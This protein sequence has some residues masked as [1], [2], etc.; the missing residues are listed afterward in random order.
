MV[1]LKFLLERNELNS[2]HGRVI[3]GITLVEDLAVVAMTIL[4]P[5]L[6][7][8][9]GSRLPLFLRGLAEA[10]LILGPLL[11]VAHRLMP[12]VL[13]RVARMGNIELFLLVTVAIAIGTAALTAYLGLSLALGAFLAGLVISES[14]FAHEAMARILPIRDVFVAMFFVS[15]GMLVKPASLVAEFPT[16]LILIVIVT[17]GKFV[18]WS[19]IV[20]FAGYESGTAILAGLGLTQIRVLIHLGWCRTRSQPYQCT[21]L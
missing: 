8:A 19:G 21:G 13:S 2:P 7:S 17:I 15:I 14:E 20:R 16:V 9:S 1:I 18:I 4:L 3:V 10:V 12:K 11:W 6:G 5:A